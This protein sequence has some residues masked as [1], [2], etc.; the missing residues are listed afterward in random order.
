M[1]AIRYQLESNLKQTLSDH[2]PVLA[3]IPQFAGDVI[4]K[5]RRRRKD[6]ETSF[7]KE[8]GKKWL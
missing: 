1:R 4:H 3:F 2:D 8:K 6:G 7:E 5:G